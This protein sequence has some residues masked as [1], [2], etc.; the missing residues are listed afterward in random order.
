M[1][2]AGTT[3]LTVSEG[4]GYGMLLAVLFAGHDPQ[5]QALFDGLLAV[6]RARP[7]FGVFMLGPQR[8]V[9]DGL[10]PLCQRQPP[11]GEGWNA[12]DGDLDIAMALL[13]A[14]KQWGSTGKWNYLQEGKNT[15][16]AL[17]SL[18]MKADGTTKGLPNA[19]NNRTSDYMIGHFRAFKTATG[20]ALWDS[21]DRPCLRALRPHADGVLAGRGP[22]ARL[23]DR[24][25]HRDARRPRTGFIGDG[26]DKEGYFWWNACRNPWRYSTDYLLSGDPRFAL[27]TGR[28]IDFF[29]A[30]PGGDPYRIG[31]GYT[32]A[33]TA[34]R[35]VGTARP[36]T[37]RS[38]QALGGRQLPELPRHDVE[39]ERHPPHHRLLRRRDSDPVHGGCLRQLVDT[40]QHRFRVW[41]ADARPHSC[42]GTA[43]G[44]GLCALSRMESEL[45][46]CGRRE[47]DEWGQLLPCQGVGESVWNV[48]SPPEWTPSYWDPTTCP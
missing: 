36:I 34:A 32:L 6:V 43:I 37:A 42:P 9:P 21:A 27:V 14:D 41:D 2:F 47:G 8:Q 39:L 46:L 23:H 3:Y 15:I 24:H 17:K 48:N 7:A 10:A 33:G 1:Q 16:A 44:P 13:M 26:N 12:M 38:A 30:K 4:M 29:K 31:T 35:P 40:Y 20:D 45:A 25:P 22:D 11:A 28:M 18:N 19:N 5:A